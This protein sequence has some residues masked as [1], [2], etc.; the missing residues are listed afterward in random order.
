MTKKQYIHSKIRLLRNFCI[1]T[2]NDAREAVIRKILAAK[3]NEIQ[4]DNFLHDVIHGNKTIDQ[5]IGGAM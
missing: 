4:I 3:A 5:A 2:R 1:I